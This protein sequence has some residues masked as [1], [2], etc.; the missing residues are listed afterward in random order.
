MAA[1]DKAVYAP[2]PLF[3]HDP[4]TVGQWAQNEFQLVGRV[5]QGIPRLQFSVLN[6]APAQPRTGMVAYADGTHWNPGGTGEGLYLWKS[7][8]AWHKIV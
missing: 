2:S 8:A 5:F 4:E 6:R 3:S 7:D 1:P